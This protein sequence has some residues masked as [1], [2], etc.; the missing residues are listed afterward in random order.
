MAK[1][2][3]RRSSGA[4]A[5]ALDPKKTFMQYRAWLITALLLAL[6]SV[7]GGIYLLFFA[8]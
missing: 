1:Q 4:K 5:I 3:M 8:R 2:P 7:P 6:A